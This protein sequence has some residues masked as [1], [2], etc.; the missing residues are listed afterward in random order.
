MSVQ[1][2][3]PRLIV[4]LDIISKMLTFMNDMYSVVIVVVVVIHHLSLL[5]CNV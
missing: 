3:I 5:K 4:R 1:T 2:E